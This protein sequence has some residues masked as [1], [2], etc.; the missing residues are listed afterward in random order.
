MIYFKFKETLVN[1]V[2]LLVYYLPYC[3]EEKQKDAITY[4]IYRLRKRIVEIEDM[5]KS[6]KETEL[7]MMKL[8]IE[9]L[10]I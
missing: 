8:E 10:H 3:S 2:Q 5:T 9:S 1:Q 6:E 7:K 4:E